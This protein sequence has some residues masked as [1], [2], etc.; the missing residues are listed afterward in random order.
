MSQRIPLINLQA[1]YAPLQEDILRAIQ[2]VCDA[3]RFVLGEKGRQLEEAVAK[4][5]GVT[6]AIGVSSGTD[7]LL[8]SLMALGIGP[9][10]EVLTTP[11][12][13]FATAG[14]IARLGAVPVF[15]DIEP[16]RMM[17]DP[18]RLADALA[19][20]PRAKAII[21]VHLFGQCADMSPILDTARRHGLAVIE[22]AAQALGAQA[23]G[24]PAGSMGAAGCFS[25]FPTKNLG[26]FGDAGMVT[27]PDR[28]LAE[29]IR[30]LRNHGSQPK[31]YHPLLGGNFRLDELQAAVL[32]VKLPH[33]AEWNAQRQQRADTYR[34]LFE[35][36]GLTERLMLPRMRPGSPCIYHQ[37]V[38]RTA[39]RDALR[40]HLAAHGVDTEIYYP[41]PLHLQACYRAL[42]YRLGDCPVAEQAAREVLALP[43]YPELP[44]DDQAAVVEAIAGFFG[45]GSS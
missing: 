37:Y 7:A 18:Q 6:G 1:Q 26:A 31:Y 45:R 19:R 27:T 16:E 42:G 14:S 34:E 23:D 30:L 41:L 20:H 4:L 38:V 10:D 32:L 28:A 22:D 8:V 13:F 5:T 39:K 29:K 12:T 24:R 43:M 3:Q 40:T 33:L 25:F 21:P 2:E 35:R 15:V 44:P 36:H 11:F 17:L 9:G